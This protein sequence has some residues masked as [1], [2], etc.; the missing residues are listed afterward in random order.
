MAAVYVLENTINNKSYIGQTINKVEDR[1]RSHKKSS[2]P[3]GC[4]IRKYGWDN[5]KTYTYYV[6]E[7]L[8]DYFEIEMIKKADCLV[9]NG[10]NISKGGS[11]VMTG[12]KLSEEH[13]RKISKGNKGKKKPPRSKEHR[14]NASLAQKNRSDE[15]RKNISEGAKGRIPWNKGKIGVQKCSKETRKKLSVAAKKDWQKRKEN[16]L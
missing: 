12:L 4:A 14:R 16:S 8:L 10:Y 2:Y 7:E 1:W 13:K 5:F 9:P 15:K 3:I 6:P 11:Q